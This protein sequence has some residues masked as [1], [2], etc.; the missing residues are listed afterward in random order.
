[1]TNAYLL[2]VSVSVMAFPA[3]LG[4]PVR[5]LPT[6]DKQAD[7]SYERLSS[8]LVVVLVEGI[9]PSP[10]H[11]PAALLKHELQNADNRPPRMRY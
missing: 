3:G 10:E 4:E 1:M 6:V 2:E 7:N 8:P 5:A 11:Q 9:L